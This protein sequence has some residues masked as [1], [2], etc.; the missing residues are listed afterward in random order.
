MSNKLSFNKEK[1]ANLST[2]DLDGVQGG[3]GKLP[4]EG[5]RSQNSTRADFT[6]CMCTTLVAPEEGV[7]A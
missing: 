1:I 3:I 7:E 4:V 2:E 5:G 6:C